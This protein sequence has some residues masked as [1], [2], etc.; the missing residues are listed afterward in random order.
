MLMSISMNQLLL[1]S[2]RQ[3]A[4]FI[5]Q[6]EVKTEQDPIKGNTAL[7]VANLAKLGFWCITAITYSF[8]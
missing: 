3:K 7:L 5:P 8:K 1:V 2:L 6:A 4:V